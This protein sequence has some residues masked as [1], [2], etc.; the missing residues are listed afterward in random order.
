ME[1][2]TSRE[3][4][5]PATRSCLPRSPERESDDARAA[6]RAMA[7]AWAGS[8]PPEDRAKHVEALVDRYVAHPGKDNW[9]EP[10]LL[11]FAR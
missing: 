5:A 1:H 7:Q 11:P 2:A 3:A 4:K 9:W 6:G 10:V 8:G